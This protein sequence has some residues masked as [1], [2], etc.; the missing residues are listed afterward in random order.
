MTVTVSQVLGAR[1]AALLEAA[2]T[3]RR[4]ADATGE[5]IAQQRAHLA[6]LA[7]RWSGSASDAA[8]ER[9]AAVLA[10][11]GRH[12]A[13]LVAMH[14]IL[15][16]GGARLD[17]VRS[18]LAALVTGELAQFWKIGD[19]GSVSPGPMLREY[20]S[21]S[22]V[23]ELQVRVMALSLEREIRQLLAEF[24]HADVQTADQLSPFADL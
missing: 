4:S 10:T 20:G 21:V 1:P 22:P 23:A 3:L 7:E 5:S 13:T 18:Q 24:E 16:R 14:Q 9:G 15:A 8:Q 11:Q 12:R 17:E 19:D 6:A 2:A